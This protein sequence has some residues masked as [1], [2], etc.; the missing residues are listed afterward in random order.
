MFLSCVSMMAQ[1]AR[2]TALPVL[3]TR[4]RI[5]PE[6]QY[7]W[8][9]TLNPGVDTLLDQL[10]QT[11]PVQLTNGQ[12]LG[13]LGSASRSLQFNQPASPFAS[14]G[15]TLFDAYLLKQEDIH[16]WRTNKRFTEVSYHMGAF[17]EG[18]IEAF[19]SQ[20]ILTRW[21]AGFQ[22]RRSNVQDFL[23]Q[24]NSYASRFLFFT[25]YNSK[26]NR[27]HLF[28]NAY[29]NTFKQ[30]TNGGVTNDSFYT[31]L[32]TGK[33]DLRG[34]PVNLQY[35]GIRYRDKSFHISQYFVLTRPSDSVKNQ[36]EAGLSSTL[37]NGSFAYYD[38]GPDSSFY[39]SSLNGELTDDSLRYS[40]VRNRFTMTRRPMQRDS[41]RLQTAVT[42]EA[43]H[44]QFRFWQVR[45]EYHYNLSIGGIAMLN[46]QSWKGEL[47]YLNIISGDDQTNYNL[48]ASIRRATKFTVISFSATQ[49]KN[50]TPFLYQR[51]YGNHFQWN[52]SF[53]AFTMERL[54]AS[55]ELK[56]LRLSISGFQ[57]KVNG[58]R[59]MSYDA[60]PVTAIGA[61]TVQGAVLK[62]EFRWKKWGSDHKVMYQTVGDT[63]VLHLPTWSTH[64]NLFW[65]RSLLNNSFVL[66]TGIEA[67]YI[68]EFYGDAFMPATG[69]FYLQDS[70]STGN[71]WFIDVFA[72][73]KIKTAA[74][75][76]KMENAA[77]GWITGKYFLTPHYP[78]PGRALKFGVRWQ[79]YDQ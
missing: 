27:Y 42:L 6:D 11:D 3:P 26:N 45:D 59:Y 12:N 48:T 1:T 31:E 30:Q 29:W 62:K 65:E 21:N 23:P 64:H 18:Q 68:S 71:V 15:F 57:T 76:I 2:D 17:K 74:F 66:R 63:S 9:E 35:A 60:L 14:M 7:R 79:F 41:T 44:Q 25:D 77:D 75:F 22:F 34:L 61:V 54:D 67:R 38:A 56:Q 53:P 39:A 19:H 32:A 8:H 52:N 58:Y 24:S 51:M 5:Y 72:D 43:S 37:T 46:Y 49:S 70:L 28:A 20:N 10:H 69:T 73:V 13:T 33:L 55:L 47:S 16:Y 78:G 36:L 50:S 40:D 4:I